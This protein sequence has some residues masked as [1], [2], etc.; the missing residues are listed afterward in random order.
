MEILFEI[1]FQIIVWILQFIGELLLQIFG[2]ALAELGLRS[3][4]EPFR[5]PQPLHPALAGLGYFLFGLMAGGLSLW[6]VPALFI[7]V[8]WLRVA[9]LLVMPLI[10]GLVMSAIGRFRRR[11]GQELIRLDTFAYG[12][13]FA[14]GMSLVRFIWGAD[15]SLKCNRVMMR[16]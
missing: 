1:L 8:P 11:Q 5:R 10:A 7:Q 14:F 4:R 3:L 2:E 9:N 16:V 15:S 13:V 12:A 6:V